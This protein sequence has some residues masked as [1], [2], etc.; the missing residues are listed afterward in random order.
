[1]LF[2]YIPNRHYIFLTRQ[3]E[4]A[5]SHYFKSLSY[6][7]LIRILKQVDLENTEEKERFLYQEFLTHLEGY[8]VDNT[9]K[10]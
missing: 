3:G 10:Q 2:S 8:I 4:R 1:M 5:A 7:E 6:R 9:E